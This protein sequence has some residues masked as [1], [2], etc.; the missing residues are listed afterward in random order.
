MFLTVLDA[1][2]FKP[3]DTNL[4]DYKDFKTQI[5]INEDDFVVFYNSRNIRRK[6]IPDTLLAFK[7]FKEQLPQEK[8]I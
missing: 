3:I 7:Y 4:K 8:A 1:D 6:Q 5:G 2:T